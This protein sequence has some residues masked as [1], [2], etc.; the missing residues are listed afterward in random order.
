[1]IARDVTFPEARHLRLHLLAVNRQTHRLAA[2]H[3]AVPGTMSFPR[4]PLRALRLAHWLEGPRLRTVAADAERVLAQKAHIGLPG[5]EPV[6]VDAASPIETVL[7]V[8]R[9]ERVASDEFEARFQRVIARLDPPGG[10]RVVELEDWT[11][12][13]AVV[14]DAPAGAPA[15]RRDGASQVA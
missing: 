4:W 1:M 6:R 10:V 2:L 15:V 14:G 12:A 9:G 3:I 11:A 5:Y 13:P 8:P 7:L